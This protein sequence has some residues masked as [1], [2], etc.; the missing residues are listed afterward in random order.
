[1]IVALQFTVFLNTVL[2]A[3][4]TKPATATNVTQVLTYGNAAG[5]IMP[6]SLI[7]ELRRDSKGAGS[8]RKLKYT[9]FR[10][11]PLPKHIAPILDSY[12]ILEPL[13]GST[14]AGGYFIKIRHDEDWDYYSFRP[15]MGVEFEQRTTDLYE[16]IFH[17]KPELAR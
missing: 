14:E 10:G 1:M 13:M 17:R 3:E 6:P 9:Y 8:L 12:T 4:T 16:M 15:A 7:E 11:A 5:V 2:V